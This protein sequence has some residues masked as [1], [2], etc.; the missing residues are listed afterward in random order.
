[1]LAYVNRTPG[2]GL[3]RIEFAP[4]A[5]GNLAFLTFD[6]SKDVQDFKQRMGGLGQV[7]AE[8]SLAG[9]PLLVIQGQIL[10]QEWVQSLRASGNDIAPETRKAKVDPWV[11]RSILGI[12]GQSLQLASS[13]MR[14][15][16]IVDSSTFVFAASNLAANGINLAYRAQEMD[17]PH[18]LRFLKQ[19]INDALGAKLAPGQ[20]LLSVDDKRALPQLDRNPGNTINAFMRRNSVNVGELG[21]RYLGAFGLAFPAGSWSK[22]FETKTLPPR[23]PS[24]LR[25][26]VGITSIL[27]KTVALAS[28]TPD[29]YNPAPQGIMG[30]FRSDYSFDV[31]G[32]IEAGAFAALAGE[33]FFRTGKGFPNPK[34]GKID[35]GIVINGKVQRDWIGGIGASMFVLG[36]ITRLWAKYGTRHVNMQELY[37][38][39]GDTLAKLPPEKMQQGLVDTAALITQNMSDDDKVTFSAVYKGLLNRVEHSNLLAHNDNASPDSNIKTANAEYLQTLKSA[40]ALQ[41]S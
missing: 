23:N 33:S 28:T 17:D 18:R 5:K 11:V 24:S 40:P 38:H 15:N 10:A 26:G 30:K 14:P 13:F 21:L 2:A 36:Y 16:G 3:R 4:S 35:T 31:G 12:G 9:K 8:T 20:S 37:A 25:Y 39:A 19:N 7:V 6:Q 22:A 29:P 32:I 34:T 1:M 41:V 27:G